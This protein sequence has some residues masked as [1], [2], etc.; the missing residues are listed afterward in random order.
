MKNSIKN[1]KTVESE[2]LDDIKCPIMYAIEI[3]GQKWKLPILWSLAEC[4]T[5][6]YNEL[7]RKV[8]GVTDTMLI[9][10]LKELED[11]RLVTRIQYNTIPPKV[12]Y[13]LTERGDAL[14]PTLNELSVWGEEQMKIDLESKQ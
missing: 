12:E 5:L 10:C 7:K 6:R 11:S 9:K 2:N 14:L 1:C 4:E 8:S 13:S 3:I